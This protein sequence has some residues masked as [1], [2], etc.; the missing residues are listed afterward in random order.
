MVRP[1]LYKTMVLG[2]LESRPALYEH[3][4]AQHLLKSRMDQHAEE[5]RE[6][7]LAW[8]AKLQA[9]PEQVSSEA[10]EYALKELE[11]RLPLVSNG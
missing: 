4:R 11:D 2:L 10:L 1:M 3:L 5:L 8:K 9:S 7:H 6:S